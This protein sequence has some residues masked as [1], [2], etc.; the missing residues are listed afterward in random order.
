MEANRK[1]PGQLIGEMCRWCLNVPKGGRGW[2]CLVPSCALQ[3]AMPWRGR[4]LPKYMRPE[5]GTPPE[6]L[7][8]TQ[9]LLKTIPPRRPT[10]GMIARYCRQCKTDGPGDCTIDDC[11]LWEYRPF[12][13]G[14]PPKRKLSRKQ[15]A[16]KRTSMEKARAA[17]AK[18][19]GEARNP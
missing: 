15:L 7:E 5:K 1:T 13:P 18:A 14:G 8:R 4:D 17:R 10:K 9:T 3:S 12:Q 11:I 19:R 16:V 6:D 2:D